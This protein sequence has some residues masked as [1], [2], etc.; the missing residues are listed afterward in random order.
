MLHKFKFE[1]SGIPDKF[2]ASVK[3][4]S[5][6]LRRKAEKA[7]KKTCFRLGRS[8][9]QV[10]SEPGAFPEF[11]GQ[12]I[13]DTGRLRASQQLDFLSPGYARFSWNTAYAA[14]VLRGYQKRNGQRQPGRN[15][16]A[17]GLRRADIDRVFKEEVSK[18]FK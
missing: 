16:V 7:F 6:K 12:D 2:M 11:P 5:K 13:V 18:E 9:T 10:I 15:W 17:E 3:V 4:N 8:F 14:F 1:V